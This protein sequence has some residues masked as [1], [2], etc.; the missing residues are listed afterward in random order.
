LLYMAQLTTNLVEQVLQYLPADI[1]V[2]ILTDPSSAPL[3]PDLN[4]LKPVFAKHYAQFTI[5]RINAH[6]KQNQDMQ[7]IYDEDM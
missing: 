3:F 5:D 6:D 1:L 7:Y 4:V 2:F